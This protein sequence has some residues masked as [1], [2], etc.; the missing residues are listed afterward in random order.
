MAQLGHL[1]ESVRG[2]RADSPPADPS[3][4][5]PAYWNEL[6]ELLQRMLS[7]QTLA[8]TFT[9]DS[10]TESAMWLG[11]LRNALELGFKPLVEGM[12][13][14]ADQQAELNRLLAQLAQDRQPPAAAA[15]AAKPAQAPS[16]AAKSATKAAPKP[17]P[18][19][20]ES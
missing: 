13:L 20:D 8:R 16:G 15:A 11:G 10:A 4:S 2:L 19:T 17:R 7:E 9:R 14:R 18:G 6:R 1:V 5:E 3:T 12:R